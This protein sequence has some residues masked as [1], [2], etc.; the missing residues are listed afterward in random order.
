MRD[1][2]GKERD[3]G[4]RIDNIGFFG[5]PPLDMTPE[6]RAKW[7]EI[8]NQRTLLVIKICQIAGAI[9]AIAS[10]LYLLTPIC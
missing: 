4:D 10:V 2:E 1:Q 6:E 3:R 8:N 5:M 7:N 9:I